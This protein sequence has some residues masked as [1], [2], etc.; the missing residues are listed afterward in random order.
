MTRG[1]AYRSVERTERMSGDEVD[2]YELS[3]KAGVTMDTRI[4]K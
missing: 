2:L 1:E 3:L 4:F